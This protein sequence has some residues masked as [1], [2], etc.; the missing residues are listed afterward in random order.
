MLLWNR[1]WCCFLA[2]FGRRSSRMPQS[3]GRS[4]ICSSTSCR[5]RREGSLTFSLSARSK[6]TWKVL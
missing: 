3:Q 6:L 2:L 1:W 5:R 4:L